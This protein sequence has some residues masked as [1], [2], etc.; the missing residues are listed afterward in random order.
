[1]TSDVKLGPLTYVEWQDCASFDGSDWHDHDDID[2]L[3]LV[4]VM[5]IGWLHN[6]TED[7]IILVAH[8]HEKSGY[9][10]ICIPKKVITKR[11]TLTL[12]APRAPKSKICSTEKTAS[13]G[14]D[15]P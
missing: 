10:E 5:S 7:A 2:A 8:V 3:S 9:G 1:M 4:R 14:S 11:Q 15:K 6:E 12:R 13:N